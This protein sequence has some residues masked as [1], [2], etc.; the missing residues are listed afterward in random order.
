[1]WL[2]RHTSE[3]FLAT[4]WQRRAAGVVVMLPLFVRMAAGA[5]ASVGKGMPWLLVLLALIVMP[6]SHVREENLQS[7]LE[8]HP[9][10]R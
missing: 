8:E 9:V 2:E 10:L 6:C 7:H 1:M 5:G 3:N 4:P